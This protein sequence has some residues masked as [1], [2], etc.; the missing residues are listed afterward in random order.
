MI[1]QKFLD[2]I[3]NGKPIL[4]RGRKSPAISYGDGTM[5]VKDLERVERC[6]LELARLIRQ[7]AGVKS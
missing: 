1:F 5:K 7:S 2:W 4:P 3:R 6:R